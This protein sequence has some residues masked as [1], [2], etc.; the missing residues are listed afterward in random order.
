MQILSDSLLITTNA[1]ND[2]FEGVIMLMKKEHFA[3]EA[4]HRIH[5]ADQIALS[6]LKQRFVGL[7]KRYLL[8]SCQFSIVLALHLLTA[9][10]KTNV[11][12]RST[13]DS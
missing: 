5:I 11:S 9:I 8:L 3:F 10:V 4:S 2:Y 1:F 6:S 7:F 12:T 13:I